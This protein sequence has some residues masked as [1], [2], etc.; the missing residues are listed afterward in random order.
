[1]LRWGQPRQIDRG[2][3]T[4]GLARPRR[5]A[6]PALRPAS[7][8]L[9]GGIPITGISCPAASE[10]IVTDLNGNV[11]TTRTPRRPGSWRRAAVDPVAPL[12][13]VSCPSPRF[14]AAIDTMGGL[15]TSMDPAGGPAAWTRRIVRPP[16]AFG[17]SPVPVPLTSISCASAHLCV[18]GDEDPGEILTSTAP[19]GGAGAW[20]NDLGLGA[21]RHE[22]LVSAS[23]PSAQFC[24]IVSD[25]GV[26]AITAP[27]RRAST[28]TPVPA[29]LESIACGSPSLCVAVV[30]G[31]P[32]GGY[33]GLWR[34]TDPAR[35]HPVWRLSLTDDDEQFAVA[36]HR[37][38]LC[39]ATDSAGRVMMSDHPAA[40]DPR[41]QVRR[42]DRNDVLSAISCPTAGLCVAGDT[43]GYLVVGVR[44]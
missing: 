30:G 3:T 37:R 1:M 18:S 19:T 39:V 23:C 6:V 40:A 26:D 25:M 36:C 31:Q 42:V 33:G 35:R 44:P 12:N 41:W 16:V 38:Q 8:L 14:C 20:Q 2:A 9:H 21:R 7:R 11:L 27:T 4:I 32:Q 13:G 15:L 17:A 22:G 29:S 34:S 24:A 5:G 28:H 10:C 43:Y